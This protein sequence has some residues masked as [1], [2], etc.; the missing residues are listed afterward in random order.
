MTLLKAKANINIRNN[1]NRSALMEWYKDESYSSDGYFVHLPTVNER[2]IFII[3]LVQNCLAFVNYHDLKQQTILHSLFI[4]GGKSGHKGNSKFF[5]N[6]L[7]LLITHDIY[8]QCKDYLDKTPLHYAVCE[9]KR[10]RIAIKLLLKMDSSLL[11]SCDIDGLTPL[12]YACVNS[13]SIMK[14]LIENYKANIHITDNMGWT[15]LLHLVHCLNEKSLLYLCKRMNNISIEINRSDKHGVTPLHAAAAFKTPTI[16]KI[17]VDCGANVNAVDNNNSTPLHYAYHRATPDIVNILLEADSDPFKNDSNGMTPV[18]CAIF[19]NYFYT[20]QF[21]DNQCRFIA[22]NLYFISVSA[23]EIYDIVEPSHH[24]LPDD[25]LQSYLE[26]RGAL[27]VDDIYSYLSQMIHVNGIGQ[28]PILDEINQ[29]TDDIELFVEQ[30]CTIIGNGCEVIINSDELIAK[31]SKDQ[32]DRQQFENAA[33]SMS[34]A[35]VSSSNASSGL[36]TQENSSSELNGNFL[37]S[38]LLIQVLLKMKHAVNDRQELINI[39]NETSTMQDIDTLI[40]FRF[41]ITDLYQQLQSEAND[42]DNRTPTVCVFRDQLRSKDEL[43]GMKLIIRKY[44]LLNS[45]LSTTLNQK[46]AF[47]FI[48]NVALATNDLCRVVFEIDIDPSLINV[49]PYADISLQSFFQQE[50]EILFMLGSIFKINEIKTRTDCISVIKLHLA[51]INNNPELQDLTDY[52]NKNLG[53]KA[54]LTSLGAVLKGM[55]KYDQAKKCYERQA[56]EMDY[57]NPIEV[58]CR[59]TELGNVAYAEGKHVLAIFYHETVLKL[60]QSSVNGEEIQANNYNN[61]GLAYNDNG[62]YE[63]ALSCCNKTLNIYK[64]MYNNDDDNLEFA[65][66]Y[67]NIGLTCLL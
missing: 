21:P 49:E 64:K 23:D 39:C 37:W 51:G 45:C 60:F 15:I 63:I 10:C 46:V 44:L 19:R 57:K 24:S 58:V 26:C 48:S 32:K 43:D 9:G 14:L 40:A 61:L 12:I 18:E 36:S 4:Y 56:N 1:E 53:E 22:D 25:F 27:D 34:T 65:H 29:L 13:F 66:V 16:V 30:L 55:D 42:D 3:Y 8:V 6:V 50:A 11:N 28:L 5:L 35:S 31:I 17:L 41:F 2:K 38:Q 62:D 33:T 7:Q 67:F 54:D 52:M 59:Y 47:N 20:S